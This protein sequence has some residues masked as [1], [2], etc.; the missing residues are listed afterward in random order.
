M[1][2]KAGTLALAGAATFCAFGATSAQAAQTATLN[3]KCKFPLIGTQPLKLDITLDIPDSWPVGEP[4]APFAITAKASAGGTTAQGLGLVEGLHIIG[5]VTEAQKPGKGTASRARVELPDGSGVNVR[6]PINVEPYTVVP[7]IPNPL[8]L[9]ASGTTPSLTLDVE[10]TAKIVLTELILNLYGHYEDGTPV[11][12][13]TTPPTD[14][15]RAPYA[16]IDGDPGTFNVPCVLDPAGQNLQLATFEI[17]P[18][19]GGGDDT[20]APSAPVVPQP[21]DYVESDFTKSSINIKWRPATDNVGVTEYK[22]DYEGGPAGGVRVPAGANT[23]VFAKNIT[24]LGE[25]SEYIFTITALDAAGNESDPLE[26]THFTLGDTGPVPNV[27]PGAPGAPTGTST[28]TTIALS[29]GAATDSDGT[30]AKY[31]VYAGTTKVAT[32]NGTTRTA[33]ITGLQPNTNYTYTVK[34]TDDDGAEGPASA[35]GTVKTKADTTAPSNPTVTGTSTTSSVTLNWSAST[36]NIG[37]TG[38]E[39]YQGTGTTPVAS[40]TGLTATING[41]TANTAYNFKVVAKDAAGNKSSGGLATVTTKPVVGPTTPTT[42]P[43]IVNYKYTLKGSTTLR[44]L[45]KGTLALN[46]TIAAALKLVDGSFTAD[47]TLADTSARLTSLG[48]LPVTA[49]VGLV[50][51]G[52]TTGSLVDG[53]L[54]TKSFVRIKVKEVKLFG[55]IPLAGG[56]SCQTKNLSEINLKSTQA[57]FSPLVGGPIAGTYSI[58]DLNGCGLLN[59]L[60]SPLTAGGGNTINLNLIPAS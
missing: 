56:N 46:G 43:G 18:P 6:V 27:A 30:I 19:D 8:V 39:V 5:G 55:A 29:W 50:P 3:Y 51:S 21:T 15:N 36:D 53:V 34:A 33:S 7:P 1:S 35:A 45:T 20:E 32:T 37:V 16:D 25:D 38:Y 47:L 9:N 48:F 41:L 23:G 57:E 22:I 26:Q 14:I 12:G 49:K 17:T 40:G 4:T 11:E 52:K 10:G 44:T 13:L 31:D 59:G 60:V 42:P 2:R 54:K 28:E 58:S 24:G